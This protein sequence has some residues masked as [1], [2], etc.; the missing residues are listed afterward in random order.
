MGKQG[1]NFIHNP[2]TLVARL[3]KA[4]YFHQG[5]YLS[6]SLGSNPSF[7]WRSVWSAKDVV[8]KDIR[9]R[10]GDGKSIYVWRDAWVRDLP[11][12]R[13]GTT[14]DPGLVNLKA[15]DLLLDAGRGWD[16]ELVHSIFVNNV[17]L[18][19]CSIPLPKSHI[20]DSLMWHYSNNGLYT[21]KSC[22]RMLTGSLHETES[23]LYASS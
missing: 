21:V 12:F 13:V 14:P 3:F 9:W 5:S 15:S 11:G 7:V 6:S 22:S 23:R 20:S 2:N 16:T 1:W 4:K 19:I 17:S 10:V 8:N 18:A